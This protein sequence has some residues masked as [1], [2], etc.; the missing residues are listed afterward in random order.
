MSET[1]RT[2]WRDPADYV[3]HGV[4]VSLDVFAPESRGMAARI[5]ST[6]RCD[7]WT[8]DD[9]RTVCGQSLPRRVVMDPH[10]DV[11]CE[12]CLAAEGGPAVEMAATLLAHDRQAVPA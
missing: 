5:V 8:A 10:E 7:V 4:L 9:T 6:M 1:A 2:T 12:A 3:V 11:T